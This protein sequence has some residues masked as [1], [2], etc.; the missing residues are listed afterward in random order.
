MLLQMTSPEPPTG[1]SRIFRT[2][3]STPSDSPHAALQSEV[4]VEMQF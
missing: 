4:M 3:E 1:Y 2:S